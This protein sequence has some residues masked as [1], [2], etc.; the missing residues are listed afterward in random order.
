MSY[1]Q[2]L[3]RFKSAGFLRDHFRRHGPELRCPTA[4][5]YEASAQGTIRNGIRFTFRD[6]TTEKRRVGYYDLRTKRLTILDEA[7]QVIVSHF[8]R[9]EEYVRRLWE[10]DYQRG[11]QPPQ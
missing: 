5:A 7:E 6:A 11:R 4:T 3:P 2:D 10:S 8:V 9:D 1:R